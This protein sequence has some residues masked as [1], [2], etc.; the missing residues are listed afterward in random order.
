MARH[1]VSLATP[2]TRSLSGMALKLS[3]TTTSPWTCESDITLLNSFIYSLAAFKHK[4]KRSHQHR[5]QF[6]L[7]VNR[8]CV[9]H[10]PLLKQIPSRINPSKAAR[11]DHYPGC[12]L[13]YCARVLKDVHVDIFNICLSQAVGSTC[14]KVT[15]IILVT[16]KPLI[17]SFNDYRHVALT[18]IVW[19][20]IKQLVMQSVKSVFLSSHNTLQFTSGQTGPQKTIFLLIFTQRSLTWTQKTPNCWKYTSLRTFTGPI[21]FHCWPKML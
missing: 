3:Q 15:S 6:L 4:H 9:W 12:T 17:S 18:F 20:C 19:K 5:R 2:E 13:K 7:Q 11:P 1:W 8:V 10:R 21:P 16:K 14:F